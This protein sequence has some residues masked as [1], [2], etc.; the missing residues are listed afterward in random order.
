MY[1][2]IEFIPVDG[3][4]SSL[5]S[6]TGAPF[7]LISQASC[8]FYCSA[9][10]SFS[11]SEK[12]PLAKTHTHTLKLIIASLT[13]VSR[14]RNRSLTTV[15]CASKDTRPMTSWGC[16][17]VGKQCTMKFAMIY[18]VLYKWRNQQLWRVEFP[19]RSTA[20]RQCFSSSPSLTRNHFT[21]LNVRQEGSPKSQ[22]LENALR[23]PA[24]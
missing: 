14:K 3:V 17:H 6:A 2:F 21:K 15:P 23:G 1:Q 20:G 12:F 10:P 22:L 16:C 8:L 18:P 19:L 7:V 4:Q 24:E 11:I 5:A 13:L 9:V